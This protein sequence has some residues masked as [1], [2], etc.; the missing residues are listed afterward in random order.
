MEK[1]NS[2]KRTRAPREKADFGRQQKTPNGGLIRI[3]TRGQGEEKR[4]VE[5]R[6]KLTPGE[7]HWA[8]HE[9]CDKDGCSHK[10]RCSLC[11]KTTNAAVQRSRR[12]KGVQGTSKNMKR[13]LEILGDDRKEEIEA[14][15]ASALSKR[16]SR[17]GDDGRKAADSEWVRS[18]RNRWKSIEYFQMKADKCDGDEDSAFAQDIVAR[19]YDPQSFYFRIYGRGEDIEKALYYY[20]KAADGGDVDAQHRVGNFYAGFGSMADYVVA[21]AEKAVAYWRKAASSGCGSE[22]C[23]YACESVAYHLWFDENGGTVEENQKEAVGL[24]QKAASCEEPVVSWILG[25]AYELGKGGLEVDVAR[26]LECY[27]QDAEVHSKLGDTT[28]WERLDDAYAFGELGLT[29]A[30]AHRASYMLFGDRLC[31]ILWQQRKV[32]V[33]YQDG[34]Y[35]GQVVFRERFPGS[36]EGKRAPPGTRYTLHGKGKMEYAQ[37]GS[38]YVGGFVDDKRHGKGTV[39]FRSGKELTGDWKGG[40]LANGTMTW[41]SGRKYAGRFERSTPDGLGQIHKPDGLGEMTWPD[42]RRYVGRF[43]G[44]KRNGHGKF[45]WPG[46]SRFSIGIE[47]VGSFDDDMMTGL[48][49]RTGLGGRGGSHAQ[50][51]FWGGTEIHSSVPVRFA[52]IGWISIEAGPVRFA[53]KLAAECALL[54]AAGNKSSPMVKYLLSD[55]RVDRNVTDSLGRTPLMKAAMGGCASVVTLLLA[56]GRVNINMP[57][58][59]GWTALMIAA[60]KG[61]AL[62]VELLL[63]D[64][65]VDPNGIERAR[66]I[67]AS[68]SSCCCALN[69]RVEIFANGG[70]ID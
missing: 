40:V 70:S 35:V 62:V 23:A 44:G 29:L 21:D 4:A 16:L 12:S 52:G 46:S 69:T 37:N 63:A 58:K 9:T 3:G 27:Q 34:K 39:K 47:Y 31:A 5:K 24:L 68:S 14:L 53:P 17:E 19:S 55:G 61:H 10:S 33:K 57:D 13:A 18:Y 20:H 41:P 32:T 54:L 36:M 38:T 43:R 45:T 59:N 15:S 22:S 28:A 64:K 8:E 50:I 11:K 56:D 48:S 30:D 6:L 65:R 60:A 51:T 25:E 1:G 49:G 66:E 67:S 26:A 2:K 7:T 42:G